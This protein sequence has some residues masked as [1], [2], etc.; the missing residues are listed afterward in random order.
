MRKNL[1]LVSIDEQCKGCEHCVSSTFLGMNLTHT[2]DKCL[3]LLDK[4]APQGFWRRGGCPYATHIVK[5]VEPKNHV[6]VGQQKQKKR[7]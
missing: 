2:P 6:R 4:K 3:K 5:E 1:N 7:G